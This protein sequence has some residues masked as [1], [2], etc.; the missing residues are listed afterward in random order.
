MSDEK[1]ALNTLKDM[2]VLKSMDVGV[3]DLPERLAF[4]T[5]ELQNI[6]TISTTGGVEADKGPELSLEN[7]LRP[8]RKELGDEVSLYL[9]RIFRL[10]AIRNALKG[11]MAGIIY[12]RAKIIGNKLGLK[13]EKAMVEKVRDLKIGILKIVSSRGKKKVLHLTE[14][15]TASG[16]PNIGRPI[17]FFEAG[18]FAG[19]LE[20]ITNRRI[21]L[22]E[23]KCGGLGD[24]ACEFVLID[25]SR[26]KITKRRILPEVSPFEV[27]SQ[28]NIELLTSLA[29]HAIRAI[30]NMAMY[31]RN[32]QLIVIDGLTQVYNHGYFQQRLR[33]ELSRSDR[34]KMEL[35]LIMLDIDKF[36]N[37][38]DSYG[39]PAG[40]EVLKIVA[41]ILENSVRSIDMVARYG[42]DE[43]AIILP[44]TNK[45]GAEVVVERLKTK[46]K[47]Y[48]FREEK[49]RKQLKLSIT[50]GLASFP[51]DGKTAE[52][53]IEK[54]D[55]RLLKHKGKHI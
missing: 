50:T 5:D 32:K 21:D 10:L 1:N 25:L 13:T 15:A 55:Q 51:G 49:S 40:D 53:L 46:V 30:E 18:L 23:T 2:S 43:F 11:G 35:S 44:Q 47:H 31:E 17:C 41:D 52:L 19:M 20:S 14:S 16:I 38:N 48:K 7:I 9:F 42:G 26:K 54:S 37:F 28:E 39:H 22:K 12:R 27:S 4:L 6:V 29:S 34:H 36:K 33:E 24:N 3:S 45:K 8:V